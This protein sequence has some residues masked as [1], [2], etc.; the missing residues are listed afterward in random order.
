ME[1]AEQNNLESQQPTEVNRNDVAV[2]ENKRI[3]IFNNF[4]L[5]VTRALRSAFT[6]CAASIMLLRNDGIWKSPEK[7]QQTPY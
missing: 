4:A 6:D 2:Y 3:T 1:C 7:R 5:E